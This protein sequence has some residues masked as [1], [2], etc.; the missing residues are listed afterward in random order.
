LVGGDAAINGHQF[1][2]M[3]VQIEWHCS[4]DAQG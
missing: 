4:D 3:T 2:Q 1:G